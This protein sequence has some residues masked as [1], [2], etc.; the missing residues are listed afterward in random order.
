M[1]I[2][3][4]LKKHSDICIYF[5]G[6]IV[7]I[8]SLV[9]IYRIITGFTPDYSIFYH[10]TVD[11]LLN[12]NPYTD[13][14]LFTVYNYPPVTNILFLPFVYLPYFYAQLLFT[15]INY[16][17]IFF[18]V[19]FSFKIL[20][21]K[22]KIKY[23]ILATSLYF[24]TFPVKFTLGMGQVNLI[25][26][27]FLLYGF[28]M[29]QNLNNKTSSLMLFLAI[30]LKPVLIITLLIYFIYKKWKIVKYLFII[31]I[32]FVLLSIILN[33]LTF[34]FYYFN[35]VLSKFFIGSGDT[36]SIVYYNQ[37]LL[38]FLSRII[39]DK[40]LIKHIY[41]FS[42]I[43]FLIIIV[44]TITKNKASDVLSFSIILC[45]I[46]FLDPI[47]WQHHFVFL[48]LPFMVLI[49][50]LNYLSKIHKL[51]IS[52][53]YL[54]LLINFKH[55]IDITRFP[56]NLILSHDF[57]GNLIILIL[58]FYLINLNISNNK[59]LSNK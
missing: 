30:L 35:S 38:A 44:I 48:F 29:S 16:L 24:I 22:L 11:L 54:L 53:A 59:N 43:T 23:L 21:F 10:S 20:N 39:T 49:A 3:Y 55:P 19:Y 8:Y 13:K 15:L 17:S 58:L 28:Y 2:I 25:A 7:F 12:H 46:L 42:V 1:Q 31:G 57:L 47:A 6:I 33:Q 32:F 45:V 50:N 51:L 36:Y 41:D 26:Y 27:A 9:S 14:S 37:G 18:I 4:F 34:D 56:S 5:F 40:T 52:V